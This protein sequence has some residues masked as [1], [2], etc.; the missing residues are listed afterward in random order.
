MDANI[1]KEWDNIAN[2]A[3]Y[4]FDVNEFRIQVPCSDKARHEPLYQYSFS[5]SDLGVRANPDCT[6]EISPIWGYLD[7]FNKSFDEETSS[8]YTSYSLRV[9]PKTDLGMTQG[10]W[11][12]VDE[13]RAD[14]LRFFGR[15]EEKVGEWHDYVSPKA[16]S[17]VDVLT[18]NNRLWGHVACANYG[19]ED[20]FVTEL[21]EHLIIMVDFDASSCWPNDAP[22]P[23]D[24]KSHVMGFFLDYLNHFDIILR[25]SVPEEQLPPLG[26]YPSIR[27]E[28]EIDAEGKT[29]E[30]R[31]EA[32]ASESLLK[33]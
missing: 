23:A 8:R 32:Y 18:I 26:F 24:I 11:N 2:L 12:S 16:Q 20:C 25:D 17:D 33:W 14:I 29:I 6:G 19:Q 5:S 22:P 31:S 10:S 9:W 13:I 15:Y 21:T 1:K 7:I 4:C 28:K 27:D 30:S 3:V